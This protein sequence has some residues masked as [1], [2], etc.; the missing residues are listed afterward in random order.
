MIFSGAAR[1]LLSATSSS[2]ITVVATVFSVAIVALQLASGQYS[3]RLLKS[4]TSDRG[5][6]AVLGAYIATFVYSLLV[7]RIVRTP[8]G[9]MEPFVPTI[10]VSVALVLAMV[11]VAL[12]IYFVH[13]VSSLIQSS[14]IVRR[15]HEYAARVLAALDDLDVAASAEEREAGFASATGRR[16]GAALVMLAGNSGYVQYLDVE[17]L[18]EAIAPDKGVA[19]RVEVPFGPGNFVSKRL[20]VDR[21]WCDRGQPPP[22]AEEGILGV[23]A[24]GDERSFRQDFAF[25]LR[26]LADVALR[27]LSPAVN[28]PTTA[29]QAMD[30]MEAIFVAIGGKALRARTVEREVDGDRVVVGIAHYGFE[31][32]AGLAFDEIRRSAFA[33]G[34]VAVLERVM[35]ANPL[36]GRRRALWSRA[37]TVARF[38]PQQVP[39]PDDAAN[40]VC[41]AVAAAAPLRGTELEA[42]TQ[43]DLR[44]LR[45]ATRRLRDAARVE[46]AIR[47]SRGIAV[48]AD[49]TAGG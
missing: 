3:P 14:S 46:R 12:L 15:A 9:G 1:S 19:A 47:D 26:E 45:A 37:F 42:D 44:E 24:L 4:F 17:A 28:D 22:G 5:V 48:T 43:R 21:V 35:G 32:V 27:G 18:A 11:C 34:Q 7:L 16:D 13:H 20:T 10:S 49:G 8:E 30:R 2:V 39:D 38:A 40:L 29:M 25:G 36:P 33:G 31:D 6:Q 23:L 41:R